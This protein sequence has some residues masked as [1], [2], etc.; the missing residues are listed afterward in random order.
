MATGRASRQDS[1]YSY[2]A[3]IIAVVIIAG[4]RSMDISLP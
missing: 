4:P 1:R 2:A 3:G